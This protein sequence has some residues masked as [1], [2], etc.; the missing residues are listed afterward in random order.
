MKRFIVWL[1]RGGLLAL[2]ATH[3]SCD[4]QGDVYLKG[5]VVKN[6]NIKYDDVR[7]LL[8][9]GRFAVEYTSE[10]TE[11]NTAL[12]IELNSNQVQLAKGKT[13]NL[14]R[15]GAVYRDGNFGALPELESGELTLDSYS[16]KKGS[17]VVGSF[18]AKFVTPTG[19]LQNLR[20]GFSADL[21][22]VEGI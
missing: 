10:S 20:G 8:L 18:N 16:G 5:S 22:V 17:E 19:S 7:V 2:L 15:Y 14:M 9:E 11:G 21:E 12:G 4:D 3:L 1:C 6:Y 13:Y